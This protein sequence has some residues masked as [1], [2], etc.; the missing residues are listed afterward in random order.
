MKGLNMFKQFI[1][2]WD[3]PGGSVTVYAITF[4]VLF[5]LMIYAKS[6]EAP[7]VRQVVIVKGYTPLS[8]QTKV[9]QMIID[10]SFVNVR[11]TYESLSTWDVVMISYDVQV[12]P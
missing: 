7:A 3:V 12:T 4:A 5:A 9:N 8:L 6:Q 11:L 1:A 2:W 10:S